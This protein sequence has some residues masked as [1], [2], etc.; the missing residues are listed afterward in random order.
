MFTT[1][2]S[3]V[4][5]LA[6]LTWQ[7]SSCPSYLA[8]MKSQISWSD[9]RFEPARSWPDTVLRAVG[10]L[11]V[12]AVAQEA[13]D[14]ESGRS[15]AADSSAGTNDMDRPTFRPALEEIRDPKPVRQPSAAQSGSRASS[16]R[17]VKSSLRLAMLAPS[18]LTMAA[19]YPP[20]TAL[21]DQS[22]R[23]RFV[24]GVPVTPCTSTE[25][26]MTALTSGQTTGSASCF[27]AKAT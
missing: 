16:Q 13:R 27:R 9:P 6:I 22:F 1:S 25:S 11:Y 19:V 3:L 2:P 14:R 15:K 12:R 23:I 24:S 26:A 17:S 4:S 21:T 8:F 7:R 10:S 20:G 5:S 18:S